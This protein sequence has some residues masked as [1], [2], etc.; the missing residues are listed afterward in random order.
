MRVLENSI[1]DFTRNQLDTLQLIRVSY[2]TATSANAVDAL[3]ASLLS[4]W[5]FNWGVTGALSSSGLLDDQWKVE[6]WNLH[7]ITLVG[8]QRML[9]EFTALYS[10]TLARG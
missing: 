2:T 5:D 4:A 9:I 8:M 3:G 10:L 6:A 7:N 1:I